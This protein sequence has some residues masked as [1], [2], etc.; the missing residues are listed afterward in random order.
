MYE[1]YLGDRFFYSFLQHV[2][3]ILPRRLSK[4]Q[5]G[6][7]FFRL[8]T[9]T[10]QLFHK[11]VV[12]RNHGS[13]MWV[14][15]TYCGLLVLLATAKTPVSRNTQLQKLSSVSPEFIGKAKQHTVEEAYR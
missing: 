7:F 9:V 6:V 8:K 12:Q 3:F 14:A 4:K 1:P 5:W 15:I 2:V 13:K 10:E 11:K